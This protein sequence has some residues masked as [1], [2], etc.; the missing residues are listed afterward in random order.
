MILRLHIR[1][2]ICIFFCSLFFLQSYSQGLI[3]TG[4][5][6][7]VEFNGQYYFTDEAIGAPPVP[8]HFLNNGFANFIYDKDNFSAG[9]RY[10]SYRNPLLGFERDYAGSGIPYRFL[11]FKKD[12]LE[13]TAGNFYDQFGSGLILRS[14]EERGLGLDNALDGL[15][16]KYS[17]VAGVTFKGLVGVQ[18]NFFSQGRGIVRG[19]DA[20]WSLNESLKSFAAKKTKIIFG[21]S[22]VSKYEIDDDNTFVLPQNVGSGAGRVSVIRGG[23]NFSAEYAYKANDPSYANNYIYKN[24]TA[25]LFNAAYSKKG[26]GISLGAKRIDNMSFRSERNAL[27]NQLVINYLPAMTKQHTN[28][29]ASFYPYATQPTGEYGFQGEIFFHLKEGSFIGGKNGADFTVNYSRAQ[30]IKRTV[31]P[32]PDYGYESGF[33]ELGENIFYEDFNMELNKRM[34]KKLRMILTYVYI[35]YNKDVVEGRPG[36][37]H[38]YSHIGI[39]EFIVKLTRTNSLRIELQHLLTEQDD[40]NWALAL[41]EYT[42]SPHWFFAA[43]SEYNYGNDNPDRRFNYY[44]LSFG[45]TKNA[46]RLSLGYGRQRAGLFCVGGVCR[47]IPASNGF[48]IS[49]TSSF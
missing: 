23:W 26:F 30:D 4:I 34:S 17:P 13:I 21:A 41:A 36:F 9:L 14:Y 5:H 46:N 10:E 48:N 11:S 6:G 8:E 28:I 43:F 47:T 33:L 39:A 24:G 29:L 22:F 18:R 31:S 19:A 20:E 44:N 3:G 38:V 27:F 49:I 2:L 25:A 7:N 37:G 15:R 16:V 45:Y 32:V 42:V 1:L 35:N 40:K 12:E